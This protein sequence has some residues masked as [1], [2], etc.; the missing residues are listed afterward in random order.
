MSRAC[1]GMLSSENVDFEFLKTAKNLKYTCITCTIVQ[2]SCNCFI[3][4]NQ[5]VVDQKHERSSRQ[6]AALY[7][8]RN[9]EI[10]ILVTFHWRW[11]YKRMKTVEV[12]DYTNETSLSISDGKMS[13]LKTPQKIFYQMYT[14]KKMH[15]FT[16]WTII[17]QSLNIKAWKLLELQIT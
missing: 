7:I 4:Q 8:F 14:E 6:R 3:S 5:L 13:N 15:I 1:P 12:T 16:E 10:S 11:V 17:M 9:I 2:G